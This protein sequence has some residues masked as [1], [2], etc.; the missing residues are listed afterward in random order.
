MWIVAKY[1]NGQL[2]TLKENLSKILGSEIEFYQP[3]IMIELRKKKFF[4]NILGNYVFCKHSRFSEDKILNN[5]KFI[6]GLSYFLSNYKLEQKQI[7]EFIYKCKN[8]EGKN[9]ILSQTFFDELVDLKARFISGPFK[10]FAF[11]IINKNKNYF[12]TKINNFKIRVKK[13]EKYFLPL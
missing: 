8:H 9:N 7:L 6:K 4:K 12:I 1:N 10:S 5:L 13:K 11:E 3:K 2:Q